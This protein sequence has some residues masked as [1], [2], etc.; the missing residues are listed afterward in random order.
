LEIFATCSDQSVIAPNWKDRFAFH[1]FRRSLAA[2][3]VKLRGDPKT[4]QGILRQEDFGT[5]MQPYAQSGM[6]AM[7][8]AQGKFLEHLM[9]GCKRP[10]AITF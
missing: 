10:R 8:D 2:A 7:R 3:L 9:E 1:N 6:E 4:V 5:T